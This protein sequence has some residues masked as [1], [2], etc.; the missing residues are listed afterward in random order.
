[1]G[2]K[3]DL[4]AVEKREIVQCLGQDKGTTRKISARQKRRIKRAAASMPLQTSK[5]IFDAACAGE[6]PR[7]S[8]CRILQSLAVMRK[9]SIRPPLN[10]ANK[11]KRLQWAQ[12]YMKTNFQTVLFTDECRA[13]LDG[14]DGWSRGWLVDG[15]HSPTRLR[16][17]QGGGGVMF[18]AGIMGRE[19][20]GPFRVPEGVKM[21]SIKMATNMICGKVV[22]MRSALR[23]RSWI[24]AADGTLSMHG[25]HNNVTVA[26][27]DGE[28]AYKI[29][30]FEHLAALVTEGNSYIFLNFGVD[31]RGQG[32]L[33][34]PASKIFMAAEVQTSPQLEEEA[35][36]LV[37]PNSVASSPQ[38]VVNK[39]PEEMVSLDGVITDMR[40]IRM[41]RQRGNHLAPFRHLTLKKDEATVK[42]GLWREANLVELKVGGS[43]V[44]THLSAQATESGVMLHSTTYTDVKACNSSLIITVV[45]ILYGEEVVDVVS[46]S[47]EVTVIK[48]DIWQKTFSQPPHIPQD[49]MPIT[50]TRVQGDV[51]KIECVNECMNE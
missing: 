19:R 3:K 36:A 4:S 9:P 22:A 24:C 16:R 28:K 29:V 49:G 10:N 39:L 42:I 1:M 25:Q 50:V 30:L 23:A 32:L 14:P 34:K 11:Q 47:G 48:L 2:R 18:W 6:V 26:L 45:G 51:T 44:F 15:H 41:V 37:Y 12:D 21:T 33:T 38:E 20:L 43:F 31:Q 13:T 27:C 46:D 35:R 7:R 8:R 17:Q 40:P 5:Q